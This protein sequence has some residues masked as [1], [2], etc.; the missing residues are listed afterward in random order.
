MGDLDDAVFLVEP[1]R[2]L[3]DRLLERLRGMVGELSPATAEPSPLPRSSVARGL[4]EIEDDLGRLAL[5]NDPRGLY[6]HCLCGE[7]W[8]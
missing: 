5:W 7:E 1:E 4:R 2:S 8:P 6:G 3:L